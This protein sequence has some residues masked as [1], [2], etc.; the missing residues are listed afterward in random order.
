MLVA[1]ATAAVIVVVVPA[2]PAAD[3]RTASYPIPRGDVSSLTQRCAR[4][5]GRAGAG[6]KR[7]TYSRYQVVCSFWL[8]AGGTATMTLTRPTR[9]DLQMRLWI[10]GNLVSQARTPFFC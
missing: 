2:A 1:L 9:C 5:I 10:K 6:V 3:A 4:A 8:T 7:I